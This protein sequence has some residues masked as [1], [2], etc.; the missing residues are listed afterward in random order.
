MPTKLGK[1]FRKTVTQNLSYWMTEGKQ[2][3]VVDLKGKGL[4]AEVSLVS[5]DPCADWFVEHFY[6]YCV[7]RKEVN[8]QHLLNAQQ[9]HRTGGIAVWETT[10]IK[11]KEEE[12]FP[13]MFMGQA[14]RMSFVCLN[15]GSRRLLIRK[16]F[17][18]LATFWDIDLHLYHSRDIFIYVEYRKV[19]QW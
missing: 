15:K 17:K 5:K 12:K 13:I 6:V 14:N 18:P 4:N 9:K 8:F 1:H 16:Q 11:A 10:C 2:N 7:Y 19:C 3:C